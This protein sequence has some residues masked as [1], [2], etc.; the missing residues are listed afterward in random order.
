MTQTTHLPIRII[1]GASISKLCV[2]ICTVFSATERNPMESINANYFMGNYHKGILHIDFFGYKRQLG[3][4]N[5][6]VNQE[7]QGISFR[8]HALS[9]LDLTAIW[10]GGPSLGV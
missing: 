3:G 4:L 5:C 6:K 7:F 1:H 10:L 9:N 2:P 8:F